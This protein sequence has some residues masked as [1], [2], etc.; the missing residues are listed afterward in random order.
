MDAKWQSI[1]SRNYRTPRGMLVKHIKTNMIR[2]D[3]KHDA[4]ILFIVNVPADCVAVL[5]LLVSDPRIV[6]SM[7]KIINNGISI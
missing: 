3:I 7:L 1:T 4:F 6:N 5:E 2:G